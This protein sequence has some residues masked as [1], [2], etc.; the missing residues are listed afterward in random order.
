MTQIGTVATTSSTVFDSNS[1]TR[2][3]NSKADAVSQ[4]V[5]MLAAIT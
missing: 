2:G 1:P 5:A 4:P 3:R